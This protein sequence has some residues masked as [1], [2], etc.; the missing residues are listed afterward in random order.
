MDRT[1]QD[2]DTK[3]IPPADLEW[4]ERQFADLNKSMDYPQHLPSQ[5]QPSPQRAIPDFQFTR[6]YDRIVKKRPVLRL[7][8]KLA[9]L[10]LVSEREIEIAT[11]LP[12]SG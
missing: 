10:P 6:R 11:G 3:N 4:M 9:G 7:C 8:R 2:V 5:A 1:K 12:R